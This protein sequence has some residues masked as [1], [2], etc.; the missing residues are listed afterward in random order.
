MRKTSQIDDVERILCQNDLQVRRLMMWN[1]FF[2]KMIFKYVR[3]RQI[4]HIDGNCAY[5]DVCYGE[6]DVWDVKW[7]DM[8]TLTRALM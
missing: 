4:I 7:M 3:V 5:F 1:V 2:V 6:N 8:R